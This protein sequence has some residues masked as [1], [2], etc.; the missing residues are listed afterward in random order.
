MSRYSS[1]CSAEESLCTA[2]SSCVNHDGKG[3][4]PASNQRVN[5]RKKQL[6]GV[7]LACLPPQS[8]LLLIHLRTICLSRLCMLRTMSSKEAKQQKAREVI[9]ILEEISILLVCNTTFYL[10][11]SITEQIRIPLLIERKSRTV[12]R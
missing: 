9:D 12:F 4:Q 10:S 11:D 7:V 3:C 5:M 8:L 6:G 1:T 2:M